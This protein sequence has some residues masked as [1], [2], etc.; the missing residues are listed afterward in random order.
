MTECAELIA[1]RVLELAN[2][3]FRRFVFG[4]GS[5]N[6]SRG[7]W[8]DHIVRTATNLKEISWRTYRTGA[9][10]RRDRVAV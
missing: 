9:H 5:Q 10:V 8:A 2:A 6:P 1:S 7:R 4:A 3:C